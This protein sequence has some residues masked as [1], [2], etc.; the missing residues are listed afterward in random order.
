M[1]HNNIPPIV[2]LAEWKWLYNRT[3]GTFVLRV[4]PNNA[5]ISE[6]FYRVLMHAYNKKDAAAII[7]GYT[8][9]LHGKWIELSHQFLLILNSK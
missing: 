3:T 8:A 9:A 6:H 1:V 4:I 2:S 7:D 5:I